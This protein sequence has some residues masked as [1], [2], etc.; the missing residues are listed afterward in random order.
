MPRTIVS[1]GPAAVFFS[2]QTMMP[3]HAIHQADKFRSRQCIKRM[4]RNGL[5]GKSEIEQLEDELAHTRAELRRAL[6][7]LECATRSV[8]SLV[9]IPSTDPGDPSPG[10]EFRLNPSESGHRLTFK[11]IDHLSP[12]RL[13]T[14][15]DQTMMG[16]QQPVTSGI[17]NISQAAPVVFV[18]DDSRLMRDT[19]RDVLE[20][21]GCVVENYASGEAF[22]E[23]A[24]GGRE[25]C[26]VIDTHL[27]GLS[28]LALLAQLFEADI[29]LPAIM[30]TGNSDIAT[31]VQAMKGGAADCLEKPVG[32]GELIDSVRRALRQGRSD[33][34]RHAWRRSAVC[35]IA[36]L[37]QRQRQVM[38]QVLS[39]RPSK[40]IAAELGISQRTVENHRAA[41]MKK[42]GCRSLPELA[43]LALAAAPRGRQA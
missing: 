31:A 33:N 39:G 1:L 9:P 20:Q 8:K 14:E 25:G 43:R 7:Q 30:I 35:H 17:D 11:E 19:L 6:R 10:P 28:G 32:R 22:L 13:S 42:S 34:Q 26:I 15:F 27:P 4:L 38:D 41:I 16:L 3:E 24:Y 18:I 40:I 21:D 23:S 2:E 36:S 37:T 29:C 5:R 12:E